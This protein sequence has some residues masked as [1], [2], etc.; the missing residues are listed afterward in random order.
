MGVRGDLREVAEVDVERDDSD[1]LG[2]VQLP[3]PGAHGAAADDQ[4]DRRGA[5]LPETVEENSHVLFGDAILPAQEGGDGAQ[6]RTTAG[7]A[8]DRASARSRQKVGLR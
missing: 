2:F 4:H 6:S 8:V 7:A 5:D 3:H 1:I